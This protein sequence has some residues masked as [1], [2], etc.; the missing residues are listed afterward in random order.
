MQVK[1]SEQNYD[2]V[3]VP[4]RMGD[5]APSKGLFNGQQVQIGEVAHES[6]S[7]CVGKDVFALV[8]R[9]F[10]RSSAQDVDMA[11]SGKDAT[12]KPLAGTQ[13]LKGYQK[14]AKAFI[15]LN[16]KTGDGSGF[17][18]NDIKSNTFGIA[19]ESNTGRNNLCTCDCKAGADGI[20]CNGYAGIRFRYNSMLWMD[21]VTKA[22][23]GQMEGWQPQTESTTGEFGEQFNFLGQ[24][25]RISPGGPAVYNVACT[26]ADCG[27][28]SGTFRQSNG[29]VSCKAALA[30][31]KVGTNSTDPTSGTTCYDRCVNKAKSTVYQEWL[32]YC[33]AGTEDKESGFSGYDDVPADAP[34]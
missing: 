16:P 27:I 33:K 21:P 31:E 9:S 25:Q 29:P 7:F 14:L 10:A 6:G 24:D 11:L 20:G 1:I 18:V 28:F 13:D 22:W 17:I 32:A 2:Q 15:G 19:P 8:Q 4:V 26:Q 23:N 30:D 3:C 12:S 5:V 34:A